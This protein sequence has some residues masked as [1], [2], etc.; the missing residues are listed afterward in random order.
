[1]L[2]YVGHSHQE[3]E[4][5]GSSLSK[6]IYLKSRIFYH[7]NFLIDHTHVAVVVAISV[8]EVFGILIEGNVV[9]LGLALVVKLKGNGNITNGKVQIQILLDIRK[10][11]AVASL[12]VVLDLL[13][14]IDAGL[15]ST[16]NLG[17][18]YFQL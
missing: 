8:Q 1:M 18:Q 4:N 11:E 17:L 13:G 6:G 14:N 16:G 7:A 15:S 5:K 3:S 12:Y 2:T 9:T 10:V